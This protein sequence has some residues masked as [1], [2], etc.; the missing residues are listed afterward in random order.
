M[1]YQCE[2]VLH[3]FHVVLN[4]VSGL[5]TYKGK[6]GLIIIL[7]LQTVLKFDFLQPEPEGAR[8]NSSLYCCFKECV[9]DKEEYLNMHDQEENVIY[10]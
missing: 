1:R 3:L 7:Y 6:E 9:E 8:E 10:K 4:K 2:E 5:T